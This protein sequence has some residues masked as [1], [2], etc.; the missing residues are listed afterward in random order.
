M[1]IL[2]EESETWRYYKAQVQDL[3]S[4]HSSQRLYSTLHTVFFC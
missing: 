3:N 2:H 4:E 1:S